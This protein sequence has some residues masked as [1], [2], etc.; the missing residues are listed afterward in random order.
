M[1]IE[2]QNVTKIYTLQKSVNNISF[3]IN[4]GEIVG[5]LGP[6]GAGKSTTMKIIAGYLKA[7]KGVAR[8][9]GLDIGSQPLEA[10]RK[11]GYLPESNAACLL[12][13]QTTLNKT[14]VPLGETVRMDV[15]LTNKASIKVATPMVVVNIPSGLS[16]QSWQLKELKEKQQF[17]Y[18]ETEG[19]Q[20][21]LYFY[22]FAANEQRK[23]SL[24]LKTE[25]KGDY[26]AQASSAYLY[27][28]DNERQYVEGTH[29]T[30]Q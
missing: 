18:Y 5:F 27:Y 7:T 30:I 19:N 10:K 12:N 14:I 28:N 1:S 29:I 23:I 20:L 16:L 11:I 4:K 24:D 9:C 15:S 22:G 2:V 26:R 6:N 17:D 21:R 13:M 8:I 3:T 25:V